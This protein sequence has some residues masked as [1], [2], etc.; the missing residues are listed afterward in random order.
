MRVISVKYIHLIIKQDQ[1][2]HFNWNQQTVILQQATIWGLKFVSSIFTGLSSYFRLIA[3][4]RDTA[5]S[6]YVINFKR[7]RPEEYLAIPAKIKS[8]NCQVLSSNNL[9]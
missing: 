4:L 2:L 6:S 1:Y 8:K 9:K 5:T 7:Y 3:Q